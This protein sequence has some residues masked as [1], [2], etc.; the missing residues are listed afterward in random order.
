LG[1]VVVT[2]EEIRQAISA[3]VTFDVMVL[4]LWRKHDLRGKEQ[5]R[6][7]RARSDEAHPRGRAIQEAVSA[8]SSQ[9]S[10]G[11]QLSTPEID[12]FAVGAATTFP[13]GSGRAMSEL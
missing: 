12:S 5:S 9:N 4:H 13:E 7:R 6:L 2:I 10:N 11:E 8:R 1:Q 3:L